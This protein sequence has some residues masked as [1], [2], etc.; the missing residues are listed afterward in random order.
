MVVELLQSSSLK[1]VGWAEYS[2][3]QQIEA[4]GFVALTPS[5]RLVWQ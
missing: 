5:T 2:E 3:A 4:L 1:L